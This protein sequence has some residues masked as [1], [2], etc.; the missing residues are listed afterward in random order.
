MKG[1]VYWSI[2]EE[3]YFLYMPNGRV[4]TINSFLRFLAVAVGLLFRGYALLEREEDDPPS[5]PA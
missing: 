1:T 5:P 4:E 3:S 2:G